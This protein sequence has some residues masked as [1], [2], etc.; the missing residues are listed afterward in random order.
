MNTTEKRRPGRPKKLK[1]DE[2]NSDTS[3]FI[4]FLINNKKYNGEY[5]YEL[6][7][8]TFVHPTEIQSNKIL[9]SYF[10][11]KTA[12]EK[13]H[14]INHLLKNKENYHDFII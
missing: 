1:I 2:Y 11:L 13:D 12:N 9:D 4:V 5:P 3:N 10:A 7:D 14:F 6:A 8:G